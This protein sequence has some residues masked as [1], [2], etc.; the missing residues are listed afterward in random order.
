MAAGLE[1]A[2]L[3][4]SSLRVSPRA[5]AEDAGVAGDGGGGDAEGEGQGQ[6]EVW[7]EHFESSTRLSEC[8]VWGFGVG[9]IRVRR[10]ERKL[11]SP[12]SEERGEKVKRAMLGKW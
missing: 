11:K 12:R 2:A 8:W 3:P 9:E 1:L 4:L 7:E 6:E 10:K 5:A